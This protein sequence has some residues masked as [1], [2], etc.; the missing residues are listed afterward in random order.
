[1]SF[2]PGAAYGP[3]GEDYIRISIT[4]EDDKLDRALSQLETWYTTR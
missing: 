4:I 1:V 3:G 2:G